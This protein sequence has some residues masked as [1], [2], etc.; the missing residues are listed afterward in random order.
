MTANGGYHPYLER[1]ITFASEGSFESEIQ[2]A[3]EEYFA[4]SG[5]VREDEPSFDARLEGFTEWYV[6]E[7]TVP[8][9][10]RTP[11]ELFLSEQRGQIDAEDVEV[12]EGFR[13]TRRTLLEFVKSKDDHIIARDLFSGRKQAF[14]ERRKL[15]GV[16]KGT[17]FDARV[18]QFR[19]VEVLTRSTIFH[20][21]EVRRLILAECKRLRRG[22]VEEQSALT[23]K[24]SLARLRAERYRRVDS[25]RLYRQVLD[26]T[27]LPAPT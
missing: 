10:H 8:S 14:F 25:E 17:L 27:T 4:E 20:L 21:D 26:G 9:R 23:R 7:R 6:L 3:R 2:L 15:A 18:L 5:P 13:L 19:G 11:L 24:L 16:D 1:L 22:A 12:Y